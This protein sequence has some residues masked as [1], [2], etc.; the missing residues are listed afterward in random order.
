MYKKNAHLFLF[1]GISF[2]II[3]LII[4]LSPKTPGQLNARYLQAN[5]SSVYEFQLQ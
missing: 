2:I 4:A 1:A 5:V 3:L